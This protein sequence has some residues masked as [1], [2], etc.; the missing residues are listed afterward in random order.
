MLFGDD[1]LPNSRENSVN[2]E[3]ISSPPK[4]PPPSSSSSSSINM[5]QNSQNSQNVQKADMLYHQINI[6]IKEVNSI[7]KAARRLIE[8]ASLD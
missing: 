2:F 5:S 3:T 4:P 1:I 8:N 6:N 7:N